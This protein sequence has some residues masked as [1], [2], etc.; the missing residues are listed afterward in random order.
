MKLRH[1]AILALAMLALSACVVAPYRGGGGGYYY[2]GG[3]GGGG[4]DYGRG[5]WRG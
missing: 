4:H 1:L 2:G 5:V 3:G